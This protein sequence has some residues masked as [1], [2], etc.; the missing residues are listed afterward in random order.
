MN[1]NLLN[2]SMAYV[3]NSK[4]YAVRAKKTVVPV[5]ATYKA[6]GKAENSGHKSFLYAQSV[7]GSKTLI[8]VK[9]EFVD[10]CGKL[11]STT[12]ASKLEF[13]AWRCNNDKRV[14]GEIYLAH[15]TEGRKRYTEVYQVC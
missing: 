7:F 5:A 8:E 14:L 11:L 1:S 3:C 9:A 12:V 2:Y 4:S 10:A 13:A 6:R 15:R